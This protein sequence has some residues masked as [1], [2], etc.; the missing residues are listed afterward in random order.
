L[1]YFHNRC[2]QKIRI[3]NDF[4]AAL[5]S[6]NEAFILF[7]RTFK[8]KNMDLKLIKVFCD[9]LYLYVAS[10]PSSVVNEHFKRA[11]N[12]IVRY[13]SQIST[14][15]IREKIILKFLDKFQVDKVEGLDLSDEQTNGSK[16]RSFG[17]ILRGTISATQ[18]F[19]FIQTR[20]GGSLYANRNSFIDINNSNDWKT[21][22]DGQVVEFDLGENFEGPCAINVKIKSK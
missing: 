9:M 3:E 20:T 13:D 22:T 7:E 2:N 21:I 6:F 19:V 10:I 18:P 5:I 8:S 12:L 1:R 14:M 15:P 11:Q 4:N 16:K 17:T